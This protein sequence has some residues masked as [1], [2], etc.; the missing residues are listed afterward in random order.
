MVSRWRAL[1][2]LSCI[3]ISGNVAWAGTWQITVTPTNTQSSSASNSSAVGMATSRSTTAVL[4]TS[5]GQ[6]TGSVTAQAHAAYSGTWTFQWV[7]D[8]ATDWPTAYT[9]KSIKS[10]IYKTV[11]YKGSGTVKVLLTGGA[12]LSKLDSSV[13]PT[14]VS[15]A[16]SVTSNT[17]TSVANLTVVTKTMAS[18]STAALSTD[19]WLKTQMSSVIA[20]RAYTAG[21]FTSNFTTPSAVTLTFTVDNVDLSTDLSFSGTASD[22][23]GAAIAAASEV[24]QG[25][26]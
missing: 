15:A 3:F 5:A 18:S 4:V 6:T 2:A 14:S 9:I 26:P 19:G 23:V 1:A 20:E 17:D 7:P 12:D 21:Y 16:P 25:V 22:S 11:V 8:N 24:Y 10:R 13:T